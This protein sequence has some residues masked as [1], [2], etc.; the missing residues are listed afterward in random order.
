[1]RW[2]PDTTPL[3]YVRQWRIVVMVIKETSV[4]TRQVD[5]LLDKES[6]RLL[7][8]RLVENPEAGDLIRG[9]W[10]APQRSVG[11]ARAAV[12]AGESE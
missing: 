12:S 5:K 10:R 3:T 2:R 7:Q 4:F 9:T 8:L 11:R 1:M 6:F